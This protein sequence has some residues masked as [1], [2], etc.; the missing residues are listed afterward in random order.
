MARKVTPSLIALILLV[1]LAVEKKLII[2]HK[3]RNEIKSPVNFHHAWSSKASG[4]V[5]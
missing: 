4:R 2:I 5:V 1:N 3:K